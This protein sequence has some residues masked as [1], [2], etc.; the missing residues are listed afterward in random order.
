MNEA[1]SWL[2][3]NHFTIVNSNLVTCTVRFSGTVTQAERAFS[4]EIVSNSGGYA[5]VS[6]PRV[7]TRLAGTIAA[8]FGLSGEP[9]AGR[10]MSLAG[11]ESADVSSAT[12]AAHLTRTARSLPG[13]RLVPAMT[14]ERGWAAPT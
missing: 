9:A 2:R 5:N 3:N 7:P 13:T 10:H 6:D 14:W 1:M 4:T 12:N 8:I 11:L